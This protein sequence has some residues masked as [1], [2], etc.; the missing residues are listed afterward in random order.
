[1]LAPINESFLD[2]LPPLILLN[3]AAGLMGFLVVRLCL[4]ALGAVV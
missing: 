1:M 3:T 4:D 2:N